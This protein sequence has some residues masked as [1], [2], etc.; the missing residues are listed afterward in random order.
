MNKRPI[1]GQAIF[2]VVLLVFSVPLFGQ[3]APVKKNARP[4]T[5]EKSTESVKPREFVPV[6]RYEFKKPEFLVSHVIIEH[7]EAGYGRITFEKRDAEE[8]ISDPLQLSEKTIATLNDL[9]G[10]LDLLNSEKDYQSPERDYSH[11]GTMDLTMRKDGRERAVSFNWTE[12]VDARALT[13]EYKKIG[14]QFIWMFDMNVARRN[15][16]LETPRIM[17]GLDSYLRRDSFADPEQML[18]YL[19]ALKDD[20]RIPLITRNHAGRVIEKIEKER[21]GH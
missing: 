5:A 19:K 7:D 14:N 20:E 9:W 21:K 17:N 13:D 3:D 10:K 12:D 16:P 2:L 15:Q 11:L 6:F 18:P 1:T 4:A 8:A